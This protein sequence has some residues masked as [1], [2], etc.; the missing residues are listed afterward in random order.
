[1]AWLYWMAG[2][3]KRFSTTLW[4]HCKCP[5]FIIVNG[6]VT[7]KLGCAFLTWRRRE[8]LPEIS[9]QHLSWSVP[10]AFQHFPFFSQDKPWKWWVVD[11]VAPGHGP[12]EPGPGEPGTAFSWKVSPMTMH[13]AN[14]TA[15]YIFSGLTRY[16]FVVPHSRPHLIQTLLRYML[17]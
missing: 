15:V 4:L 8:H 7:K 2:Y 17:G 11:L 12:H 13:V 6:I 1:M 16:I 10:L 5:D 3:S 9:R 14:N